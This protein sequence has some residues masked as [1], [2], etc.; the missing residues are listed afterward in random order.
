MP[1]IVE[2]AAELMA[3]AALYACLWAHDARTWTR[4]HIRS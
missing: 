3:G 1:A 4:K 2:R